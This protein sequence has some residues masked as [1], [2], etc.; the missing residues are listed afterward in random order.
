MAASVAAVL[1][2]AVGPEMCMK[3]QSEGRWHENI[4]AVAKASKA[5]AAAAA[6]RQRSK[7]KQMDWDS[8]AR[9]VLLVRLLL[10]CA[11]LRRRAA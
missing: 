9:S 4:M 8:K 6:V 7:L 1:Q 2:K 5:D 3:M 10:C 11:A